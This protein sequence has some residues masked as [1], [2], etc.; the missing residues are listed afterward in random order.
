MQI[1]LTQYLSRQVKVLIDRPLGSV[2]PRHKDIIYPLNYGYLSN[3]IAGDG[4]EI[5]AYIL[6]VFQPLKEIEGYVIAIIHRKDDDENKLVVAS[7]MDK[8]SKEQ[9]EALVEFQERFFDSEV[10]IP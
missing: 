6:G 8:Y 2:H 1:D 7:E 3:T 10:I 9:I 5:D 4:M